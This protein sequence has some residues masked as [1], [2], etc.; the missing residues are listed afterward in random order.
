MTFRTSFYGVLIAIA[1]LIG[2]TKYEYVVLRGVPESPS[3]VVI[4]ANDYLYEI[5]FANA[6][7]QAII[8]AGVRVVARPST[9]E[10]TT[11]HTISGAHGNQGPGEALVQAGE[12]KLREKY[13]AWEEF[14]ADYIVRTFATSGQIKILKRDT[15]EILAVM[16]AH[17]YGTAM[18]AHYWPNHLRKVLEKLRISIPAKR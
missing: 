17:D 8:R 5:A 3:I 16:V 10:V 2:C 12:A 13:L 7:E 18:E 6:T 4:P 11:E 9:K 14:E 15:K 1:S